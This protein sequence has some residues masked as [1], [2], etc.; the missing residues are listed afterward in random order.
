MQGLPE[1]KV[2]FHSNLGI[3]RK[4]KLSK[5]QRTSEPAPRDSSAER[6]REEIKTQKFVSKELGKERSEAEAEDSK[7]SKRHKTVS[8]DEIGS[9]LKQER[10]RP[11]EREPTNRREDAETNPEEP[12][13]RA[14]WFDE[15]EDLTKNNVTY[16]EASRN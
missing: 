10:N 12:R 5:R 9:F 6:A 14:L 2:Q 4:E 7:A 13:N 3:S 8:D 1:R 11:V 16:N 15:D